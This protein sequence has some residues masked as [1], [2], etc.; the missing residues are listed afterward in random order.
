MRALLLILSACAA[1]PDPCAELCAL[2]AER[3]GSCLAEDGLDW[4][5]AGYEDEADYAASCETWAWEQRLL[6]EEAG[7]DPESVDRT[8]A[9]REAALE[10]GGCEALTAIDWNDPAWEEP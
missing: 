6:A 9:A 10:Q 2:A 3:K 4:S 1:G 7:A 5:A 8:C